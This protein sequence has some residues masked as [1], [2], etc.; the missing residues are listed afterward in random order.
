V[1]SFG[2]KEH[3]LRGH[4]LEEVD[5]LEA[6]DFQI[7]ASVCFLPVFSRGK[8]NS[9]Q[10]SFGFG[11]FFPSL[12]A[13]KKVVLVEDHAVTR[14]GIRHVVDSSPEFE[15]ISETDNG[16]EIQALL[17]DARPDFLLLDLRIPGENALTQVKRWKREFPDLK[18][19]VLSMVEDPSVVQSAIETGIDGY[20]LKSDDLGTLTK[21]MQEILNGKTVYSSGLNLQSYRKSTV[22]AQATTKEIEILQRLGQGKNYGEI[23]EEIQIS[24]RTVEYHVGRLKDKFQCKTVAELIGK[25][26]QQLLI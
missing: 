14:I 2:E 19:V 7:H 4:F 23:A 18:V 24:K 5:F 26:K 13:K 11:R 21:N 10:F 9:L 16:S 20:L 6:L 1:D 17:E 25:A 12:V 22:P 3:L 15:V 8:Q